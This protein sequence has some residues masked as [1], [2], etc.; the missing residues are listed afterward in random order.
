[1][2]PWHVL[3]LFAIAY[4][5]WAVFSPMVALRIGL[6]STLMDREFVHGSVWCLILVILVALLKPLR[7]SVPDLLKASGSPVRITD[8]AIAALVGVTFML[9]VH[10][11][12]VVMPSIHAD[13]SYYDFWRLGSGY[14]LAS[15]K[16]HAV[17]VFVTWLLAPLHEEFLF[18]GIL[19]NALRTARS[20][21][22]AIVVSSVL[23]GLMH[24]RHAIPTGFAGF[25]LVLVY[26]RYG[27]LWPAILTHALVNVI[28]SPYV[29]APFVLIKTREQ[30]AT[31]AGWFFEFL[32]AALFIPVALAF[33]RRFRPD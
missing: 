29:L 24:G 4:G 32:L 19:F 22:L 5:T 6:S 18:R 9:G 28:A 25:V 15:W 33:W 13:P 10:R 16:D 2:N 1:M 27:S 21:M 31:Y 3:A 8:I 14:S 11:V 26:L 20:L 7:E 17:L 30:A 12:M 23:F